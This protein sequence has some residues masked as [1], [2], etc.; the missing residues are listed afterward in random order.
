MNADGLA[1]E[2]LLALSFYHLQS[3]FTF[4][5]G[6]GEQQRQGRVCWERGCHRQRGNRGKL[7][8]N[9]FAFLDFFLPS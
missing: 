8:E 1:I 7:N 3:L 5:F 2:F 9:E 4:F 6:P